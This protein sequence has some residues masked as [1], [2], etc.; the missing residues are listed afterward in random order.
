MTDVTR[1]DPL[2]GVRWPRRGSD[3]PVDRLFRWIEQFDTRLDWQHD[4]PFFDLDLAVDWTGAD[5]AAAPIEAWGLDD[6]AVA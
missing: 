4:D 2:R 6:L 3:G 5:Q 1:S